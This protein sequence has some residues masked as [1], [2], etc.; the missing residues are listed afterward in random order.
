MD[1]SHIGKA[2]VNGDAPE[3]QHPKTPETPTS[4]EERWR[5]AYPEFVHPGI[6]ADDFRL[7]AEKL[8]AMAPESA[9]GHEVTAELLQALRCQQLLTPLL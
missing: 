8:D 4:P 2:S 9:L 6:P 7:I 3:K 1:T 5:Q